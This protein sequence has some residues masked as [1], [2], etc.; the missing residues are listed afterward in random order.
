MLSMHPVLFGAL[1]QLAA[2]IDPNQGTTI[3][4]QGAQQ[5]LAEPNLYDVIFPGIAFL[6]VICLPVVTGA[7]VI[8]RTAKDKTREADET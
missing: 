8:W 4:R 6:L 2:Q 7:W 5:R 3:A 1:V